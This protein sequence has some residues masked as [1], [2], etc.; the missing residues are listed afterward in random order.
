MLVIDKDIDDGEAGDDDGLRRR[1]V[2]LLRLA[3]A[4][5]KPA[6]VSG[7]WEGL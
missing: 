2:R 1:E 6:M 4:S 7:P 5:R 3:G